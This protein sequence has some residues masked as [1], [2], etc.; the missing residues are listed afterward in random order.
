MISTETIQMVIQGQNDEL[1]RLANE[2]KQL[3][4][5]NKQLKDRVDL[6][7]SMISD[8]EAKAANCRSIY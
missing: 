7:E 2:N 3:K 1:V 6:M 5:E 8:L 4:E